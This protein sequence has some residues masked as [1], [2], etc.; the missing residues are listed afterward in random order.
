[1]H[2]MITTDWTDNYE[3]FMNLPMKMFLWA[4]H[5]QAMTAFHLCA[6]HE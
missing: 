2:I 5:I 6:T 1:M 4:G 3:N